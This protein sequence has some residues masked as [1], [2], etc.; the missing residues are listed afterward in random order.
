VVEFA[1]G[2]AARDYYLRR[3]GCSAESWTAAVEPC[4]S[5]A[6]CEAGLPVAWCT[7]DEPTYDDTNHGWPSFASRAIADFLFAL[8]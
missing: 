5:Y 4:R 3:N 2:E 1:R 8:P 6:N 7:H